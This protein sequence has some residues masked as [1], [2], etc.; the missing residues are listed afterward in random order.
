MNVT[1]KDLKKIARLSRKSIAELRKLNPERAYHGKQ[2]TKYELIYQIVFLRD[3]I[4][5][6]LIIAEWLMLK[7]PELSR[8]Q[9]EHLRAYCANKTIHH[10]ECYGNGQNMYPQWKATL[11]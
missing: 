8:K 3:A 5:E 4:N 2:L 7:H 9:A 6:N 1:I 10:K 11:Q